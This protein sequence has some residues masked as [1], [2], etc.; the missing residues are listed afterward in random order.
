MGY[1]A[2]KL[3]E[4]FVASGEYGRDTHPNF[5]SRNPYKRRRSSRKKQKSNYALQYEYENWLRSLSQHPD[6][7]DYAT[8]TGVWRKP[9]DSWHTTLHK[10]ASIK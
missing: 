3:G 5:K 7:D 9:K 10:K 1:N 4:E 2:S 6:H 8:S